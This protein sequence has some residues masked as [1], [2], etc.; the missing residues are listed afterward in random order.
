MKR[1]AM[2][3]ILAA[4]LV[5]AAAPAARAIG[6]YAIYWNPKNSNRDGGGAG[7]R[8]DSSLT[9]LLGA[10]ARVSYVSFAD[11]DFAIVPLEATVMVKLRT[12]YAGVGYGYYFFSGDN[13]ADDSSGWYL[14]GGLSL[15]PGPVNVFGEVKWQQLD[16]DNGGD[17]ESWVFHLG[18]TIGR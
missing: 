15:L 11:A 3:V 17:L 14:L 5:M 12:L 9:P 18:A 6:G 13:A 16:P 1:L 4:A 2:H 8:F 10:D 7:L